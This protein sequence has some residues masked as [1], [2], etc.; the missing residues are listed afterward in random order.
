MVDVLRDDVDVKELVIE[1]LSEL[2]L[3]VALL[4]NVVDVLELNVSWTAVKEL[5]LSY[6]NLKTI[7]FTIY[8]CYGNLS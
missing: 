5:K 2:L 3:L 1:E 7:S 4:D 8:P 6:H